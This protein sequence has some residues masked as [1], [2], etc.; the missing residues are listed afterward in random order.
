MGAS[1]QVLQPDSPELSSAERA[2]LLGELGQLEAHL[3]DRQWGSQVWQGEQGW[4]PYQFALYTA[5]VLE[6]L[7]YETTVVTSASWPSGSYTWVLVGVDL[8]GRM[9]WIPVEASPGQGASQR[10]LGSVPRSSSNPG[11]FD[12]RY[13]VFDQIVTLPS[14][15]SPTAHIRP[16]TGYILVGEPATFIALAS[17]DPD[18]EIILYLWSVDGG[19]TTSNSSRIRHNV[20]SAPGQY[21]VN[22]TVVDSRGARASIAVTVEVFI[23]DPDEDSGGCGCGG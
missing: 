19:R 7:A 17:G 10:T 21:T 12:E 1:P 4:T 11:S 8:G 15:A 2:A 22:L 23:E 3:A 16:P 5:G 18:G 6:G 20:F 9:A 13:V 14:N